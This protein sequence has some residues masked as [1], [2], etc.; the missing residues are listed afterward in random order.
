MERLQIHPINPQ[1]RLLAQAAAILSS[2]DGICVYPTDTVYGIGVAAT[3]IKAVNRLGALLEKDKTRLFSFI[4]SDFAQV[5]TYAHIS[6]AT[7]KLMKKYLPGPYTFLLSAT[8]LVPKKVCPK[9]TV[10]GI[11]IPDAPVTRAL[12]ALLG[13]PLANASVKLPGTLRGDSNAVA[14][15]VENEVDIM[16]DVGDLS[17]PEGSTI[18][19]CTSEEPTLI[20]L[21][22]GS[23]EGY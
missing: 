23:W 14:S 1:S 19:D 4:C 6:N 18:I 16:L 9:R 20:R 10:V 17:A 8:N 11:R 5:S 12:V 15:A 21:G 3:N 13:V 22:K 2:R 7:F